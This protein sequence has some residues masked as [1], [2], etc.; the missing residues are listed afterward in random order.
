MNYKELIATFLLLA[1]NSVVAQQ[2]DKPNII[3]IL[4]DDM[5]YNDLACYGN[6]DIRTPN[7]D[8][9]AASG[10][11]FLN[12]YAGTSVSAPSR[13]SL[14]TGLHTGHAQIRGNVNAEPYG[15]VALK[16]GTPTIASQLQKAGYKTALIGKWGLGVEGTEGE[17]SKHG[18][19]YYYGYLCQILAHNH[20]PEYFIENGKR[21]NLNNKVD[22]VDS[23]HWSKGYGSFS[24]EKREYGQDNFTKKALSFIEKNAREPFFLYFPVV[25]PHDN[26]EAPADKRYSD[27]P[28]Y[29][30]YDSKPW[31]ENEKGYA[32]MITILDREVGKIMD[33][34]D[35]LG[36]TDNTLVIFTSDNGGDSPDRF[37]V[38]SNQPFRGHK[39][40]L[41]EGGLRVPFIA[42]WHGV[43]QPGTVSRHPCTFYDMMPTFCELAHV[44]CSRTDGISFVPALKGEPQQMHEF[45]YFE[46]HEGNG[47]QAIVKNNWKCVKLNAKKAVDRIV[48]LY[49]LSVDPGEV[50]NL[51]EKHPDKVQELLL[52]MDKQHTFNGLFHF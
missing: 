44:E 5:G 43:I 6:P 32:A 36:L 25:I 37:H 45:L 1:P 30:P 27:V 8:R 3:Y 39:R 7:I 24:S 28:S 51:A 42:S 21:V 11:R 17:P 41:Y 35:E 26:G 9:L 15:Q 49:D 52:L 50:T 47:S 19:D 16:A 38:M 18:F 14:I 29:E 2:T 48:E 31:T 34:L 46:F 33:K 13:C 22:Y 10:V 4:A 40:D 23:M 12:H 20:Y